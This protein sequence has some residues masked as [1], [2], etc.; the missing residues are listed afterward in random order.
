[1]ILLLVSLVSGLAIGHAQDETAREP[2]L[3][4]AWSD[5]YSSTSSTMTLSITFSTVDLDNY[6]KPSITPASADQVY[7][8]ETDD[9]SNTVTMHWQPRTNS[10]VDWTIDLLMNYTVAADRVIFI[11]TTSVDCIGN[12]MNTGPFPFTIADGQNVWVRLV[13]TTRPSPCYPTPQE[14]DT[15]RDPQHPTNVRLTDLETAVKG[16]KNSLT[17]NTIVLVLVAVAI[18]VFAGFMIFVLRH[19]GA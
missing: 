18:L 6:N 15:S 9:S 13:I 5:I 2:D 8:D 3:L 14:L 12:P 10:S 17:I 11:G 4:L 1:M 16:V 7:S 19:Q